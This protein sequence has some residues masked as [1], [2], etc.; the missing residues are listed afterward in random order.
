MDPY[1]GSM[2]ANLSARVWSAP[3]CSSVMTNVDL[4]VI[5]G[6]L[7][8]VAA[9]LT[10]VR[11]G[12]R[13]VLTEAGDWLGG[14][15]TSQGVPPDENPWIQTHPPST[16][17][18][19]L[20]ERIRD[21]YRRNYPLTPQAA[22][23][24]LLNPGAGRVSA[25]CHE[26]RV[27]AAVLADMISPHLASGR[28]TLLTGVEPVHVERTGA[29]ITAVTVR[30]RLT[31][32]DHVLHGRLVADATELGDLLALAEAPHVLGAESRSDTG[33]L[34]APERA[35]PRDQQAIT[36]C[37]ALA[38]RPGEDHTI[39]RPASYHHWATEVAPFWPGPQLS[40]TDVEPVSLAERTRP[41]FLDTYEHAVSSNEN[42]LWHY[43]RIVS[44]A[45]MAPG[46]PGEDVTLVNWPQIDYWEL[47]LLDV[48]QAERDHALARS[49]ELTLSF[50]HW[51]QTAAPRSDGG[52]GYPELQLRGDVLGTTDGL[53]KEPYI[54]EARRLRSLVRVTEGD[55]GREQ[56][57]EHAGSALVDD[58]VGTGFYRI[59]LHPSTG[60]R[61]YIDIDCF[62]FQIPLGALIGDEIDNLVAVNK[63]IGTTH[64]TNGAYRLH[65]VEWS[66]GEAAG[67][68]SVVAAGRRM[69]SK[70]V[71]AS[72]RSEVQQ[73]LADRLGVQLAWPERIR[74]REID[75]S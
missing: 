23:D 75:R 60:G 29:T 22:T 47:P 16:S 28:L 56:R 31:G 5:G 70:D 8:G 37:V 46:W 25:L 53:A 17:Y 10:A 15:L 27:A 67:A 32:D 36:W 20:R 2:N 58:T 52:T 14:Q 71:W 9:A 4:L 6:G 45:A 68:L 7:G 34:H 57:G 24:P 39:P 18:A 69:L 44:K 42:D 43:R 59:D 49:R 40:W 72:A 73:L 54:R 30:H 41:V 74:T 21:H 51:M 19:E 35:D 12:Q 50:V 3:V 33:E 13:V 55:I 61:T 66:I 65:P 62:P 64:I 26:P 11:L 1:V 63:N 48:E 38:Y